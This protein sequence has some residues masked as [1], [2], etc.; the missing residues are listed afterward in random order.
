MKQDRCVSSWIVSFTSDWWLTCWHEMIL[1]THSQN[2]TVNT[3]ILKASFRVRKS[4]TFSRCFLQSS[5]TRAVLLYTYIF[6][7]S[8]RVPKN[9]TFSGCFLLSSLTR[10]V[11][12][13]LRCFLDSTTGMRLEGGSIYSLSTKDERNPKAFERSLIK[14]IVFKIL[15]FKRM[16]SNSVFVNFRICWQ[17]QK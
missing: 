14:R 15:F 6:K 5:L 11:L 12:Q 7:A 10:T 4:Q 3:Y 16:L 13:F 9:Q 2:W 8:L 17:E 1:D